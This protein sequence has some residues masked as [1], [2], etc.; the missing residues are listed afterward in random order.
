MICY[1]WIICQ[2]FEWSNA[3]QQQLS[4]DLINF[5]YFLLNHYIISTIVL[6]SIDCWLISWFRQDLDKIWFDQDNILLSIFSLLFNQY[7]DN[8]L[9]WLNWIVFYCHL[10][11]LLLIYSFLIKFQMKTKKFWLFSHLINIV[12]DQLWNYVI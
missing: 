10:I 12:F 4:Y 7:I 6:L 3:V 1:I 5:R 2:Y 8:L 9:Y 11:N